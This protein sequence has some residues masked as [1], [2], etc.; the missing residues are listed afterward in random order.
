[1]FT[2]EELSVI[3]QGLDLLTITGAS[4]RKMV[5]L[6]DKVENMYNKEVQKRRGCQPQRATK[7]VR[8]STQRAGLQVSRNK[9]HHSGNA[10]NGLGRT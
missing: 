2:I 7:K 4:A 3:R 8:H 9:R 10:V 1:M 5:V 6:Q